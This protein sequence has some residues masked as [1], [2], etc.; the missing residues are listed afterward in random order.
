MADEE[1]QQEGMSQKELDGERFHQAW[2]VCGIETS[3]YKESC[4]C[5]SFFYAES[6]TDGRCRGQLEHQMLP[7]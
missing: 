6:I 3:F 1:Q 2:A 5:K 7:G 4:L